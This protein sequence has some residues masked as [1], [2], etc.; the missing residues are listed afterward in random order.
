[1]SL[2]ITIRINDE[3]PIETYY[4][5]CLA[6]D[7]CNVGIYEIGKYGKDG[8]RIEPIP[9]IFLEHR[10]DLGA[11][12]LAWITVKEVM[13][14]Y[15]NISEVTFLD[16]VEPVTNY[17]FD[18]AYI[19]EIIF[20][21]P[22]EGWHVRDVGTTGQHNKL[23]RDMRTLCKVIP[24]RIMGDKTADLIRLVERQ[25]RELELYNEKCTTDPE[26]FIRQPSWRK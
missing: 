9:D 6:V 10:R 11:S 1:M 2:Y 25:Q 12:E 4:A 8:K 7:K 18:I 26:W 5:H 17:G 14:H 16:D 23:K 22:V 20:S 15:K 13:K 3:R 24:Y 21:E 19:D